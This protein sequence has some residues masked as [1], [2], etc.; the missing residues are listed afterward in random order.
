[1]AREAGGVWAKVYPDAMVLGNGR[2]LLYNGA[3][4]VHQRGTSA[5]GIVTPGYFTADR[6]VFTQNGPIGTWTQTIEDDAPAGFNNSM[7]LACTS[8]ET[9]PGANDQL[10]IRQYLEGYDAQQTLKAEKTMRDLTLS[11]WVKSNVTGTF[12]A[13]II[14]VPDSGKQSTISAAY[15]IESAN[16]WENK[17][18]TFPSGTLVNNPQ[19]GSG[20]ALVL[21]LDMD[22]GSA[23]NT[24]TLQEQWGEQN[25]ANRMVG[26]TLLAASAG[27]YFQFTGV[28]LEVGETA[29][30]FEHK[31]YVTELAECQRYYQLPGHGFGS[32]YSSSECKISFDFATTMRV[33]PTLETSGSLS[34]II[35]QNGVNTLTPTSISGNYLA[36]YGAVLQFFGM[37]GATAQNG[38]FYRV[39]IN[40]LAIAFSAEL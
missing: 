11:F 19:R 28:Q 34:K 5:T 18:I 6:W 9:S 17:T 37:S 10:S 2:N 25:N 3:M 36:K 24:G 31:K 21:V 39:N 12:I 40:P 33:A 7:K 27:N 35:E 8:A 14:S 32:F 4:Q 38:A 26:Q 22:C 15:N 16:T 13:E 29:T 20:G 1:M 23:Y 30:S